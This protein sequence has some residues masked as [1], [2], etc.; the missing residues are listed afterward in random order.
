M[1][2]LACFFTPERGLLASDTLV[3]RPTE[4]CINGRYRMRPAGYH[5]KLHVL[6]HLP[7]VMGST[8]RCL[9]GDDALFLLNGGLTPHDLLEAVDGLPA[10]L[11]IRLQIHL[12]SLDDPGDMRGHVWLLGYDVASRRVRFWTFSSEEDFKA[13]EREP[14]L[15]LSPGD[16]ALVKGLGKRPTAITRD[17]LIQALQTQKRAAD[18]A[19]D[20]EGMTPIGGDVHGCE[21]TA[22]GFTVKRLLTFHDKDAVADSFGDAA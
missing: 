9:I 14:G 2:L 11:F 22:E 16:D 4:A 6:P 10:R 3:S 15:Y 5:S 8:G 12:E 17:Q 20:E 1:T 13:R 21:I 7:A 18:G 19:L